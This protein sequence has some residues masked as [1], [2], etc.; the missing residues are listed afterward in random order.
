[1]DA[2]DFFDLFIHCANKKLYLLL[3]T[4]YHFCQP[5]L[6]LFNKIVNKIILQWLLF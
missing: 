1:M 6:Q 4:L 2:G 5:L 3:Y